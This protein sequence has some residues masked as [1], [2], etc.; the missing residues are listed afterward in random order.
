[1]SAVNRHQS[2]ILAVQGLYQ[3]N[4]LNLPKEK[5]KNFALDSETEI[6]PETR[7]YA[8]ELID[9]TLEQIQKIET[10]IGNHLDMGKVEDLKVI[11]RSILQMSVHCLL[12]CKDIPAKVTIN[13]AVILAKE[14]GSKNS[15]RFINGIMDAINTTLK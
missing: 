11:D 5:I 10:I 3:Y 12:H 2:R 4:L 1:M 6:T 7:Q 13:E 8:E 15:F 9:G 14:F